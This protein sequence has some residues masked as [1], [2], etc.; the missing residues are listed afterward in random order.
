MTQTPASE[1]QM[2]ETLA[3]VPAFA[4]LDERNR[5]K[6]ARLCTMQSFA[7]GDV[8]YEEGAMGLGLFI[9]ASGRVERYKESG[10]QKVGLGTVA[11]GGV[12]GQLAL[13]D[14]QPR[15]ASAAALEAT[16]CLLLTRDGFGTLVKKEPQI[17]WCLTPDLAGRVRELQTQALAA[18]PAPQEGPAGTTGAAAEPAAKAASGAAESGESGSS[19]GGGDDHTDDKDRDTSDIESAFFKMLRMQF[20]MMAGAAKY[21]TESSRVMEKFLDSMAD[22]TDIKTSEDWGDMMGKIPDAMVTATR[23]A[24]DH[25]EKVPRKMVDAYHRYSDEE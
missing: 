20:G 15:S 9:V 4:P 11:A 23:E 2:L 19:G 12:L 10:R 3:K 7:A 6:L 13:I 24:M 17:A 5:R 18:E 1:D 22:E 16:E 21:M 8:L 25:W 14:E